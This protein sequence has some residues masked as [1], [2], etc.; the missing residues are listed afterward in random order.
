MHQPNNA[1]NCPVCRVK[2]DVASSRVIPNSPVAHEQAASR[3]K[4]YAN[5]L[6]NLNNQIYQHYLEFIRILDHQLKHV[7]V[8]RS[9]LKAAGPALVLDPLSDSLPLDEQVKSALESLFTRESDQG[10]GGPSTI[11][12]V[13]NESPSDVLAAKRMELLTLLLKV[14]KIKRKLN[15]SKP[16]SKV[17]QIIKWQNDN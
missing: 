17:L 1:K 15:V 10:S 2:V 12:G 7:P 13:P 8:S 16:T 5:R 11:G 6:A 3:M 4:K 9:H 14:Q